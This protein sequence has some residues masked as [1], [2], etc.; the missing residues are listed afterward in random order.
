M[1]NVELTVKL[2]V[3]APFSTRSSEMGDIGVDSPL[4]RTHAGRPY[5]PGTLVKGRLRQS[6]QELHSAAGERFDP[7]VDELLGKP[8]ANDTLQRNGD[9]EPRRG[10]LY[11]S[12]FSLSQELDKAPQITRI[13]MDAALGSVRKGSY[14]VIETPSISGERLVFTGSIRYCALDPEGVKQ[15]INYVETGLRWTTG[16]GAERT[17]G[18]GRLIDV[19]VEEKTTPIVESGS[20]ATSSSNELYL[21]IKFGGPFCVAKRRISDNLFQSDIVIPGAVLKGAVAFNWSVLRGKQGARIAEGFDPERPELSRHFEKVRFR[22]AL[23]CSANEDRKATPVFPPLS[24][25]RAGDS[26]YDV[27]LCDQPKLIDG[28]T[29]AFRIDWKDDAEAV[30]LRDFG[31]PQVKTQ[32]RVRTAIS[33]SQRRAEESMLFAYEQVQTGDLQWSARIDLHAVPENDCARAEAQ[34]RSLLA[35]GIHGLGKTKVSG[36]VTIGESIPSA[37][38]KAEVGNDLVAITLQSPAILCDPRRIT[39]ASGQQEL[40]EAYSEAW[41]DISSKTLKLVR[42]FAHQSLAGG[43]YLHKRFQPGKDYAPWLLTDPGSVFLLRKQSGG[44][45]GWI[46]TSA[47]N[48]LELPA[49]ARER[50]GN[51]WTTCP[52]LAENGYGEIAVNLDVHTTK[53]PESR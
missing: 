13:Q 45:D 11:F 42:Y 40:L 23:P 41:D 7:N 44:A 28:K 25:A 4:A 43:F 32:L 5:V 33:G 12:D 17:V 1:L 38:A 6:W 3:A 19:A 24:L 22:Q 10:R 35:L 26:L 29:A 53:R 34:L 46:E 9:V 39:R 47:Q 16:L 18:F 49:W 21:L 50:Y 37:G 27:L 15:I 2:T 48:G 30:V 31:W 14:Q 20:G 51:H 52:Y 36:Q 8:T